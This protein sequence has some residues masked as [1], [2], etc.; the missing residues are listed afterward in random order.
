MVIGELSGKKI[1]TKIYD[2]IKEGLNC[3]DRNYL[4]KLSIVMASD[5]EGSSYWITKKQKIATNLGFDSEIIIVP[6]NHTYED[7]VS[8]IE[9]LNHDK[10]VHGILVQLPL[11][12][13]LEPYKNLILES[14]KQEKDVD[15]LTPMNQGNIN[16]DLDF[17]PSATAQAVYES[18]NLAMHGWDNYEIYNK[19][20]LEGVKCTI[21]NHSVLIGRPLSQMLLNSGATVSLCHEHTPNIQDFTLMSDIVVSATGNVGIW[22]SSFVS[23][24]SIIIDVTSM[25]T[26]DGFRGDF[27]MD[28]AFKNKVQ[29]WT[30][31]PG[32]IGPVTIACLM[33][34]LFDTYKNQIS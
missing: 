16:F 29:S 23:N 8:L 3:V 28:E 30:P 15:G 20:T 17:I 14:I 1:S 24:D 9:D 21:I 25:Y 27:V 13:H 12:S 6:E 5:D 26:K 19:V 2:S 31:V 4:P 11:Y 10:T 33:K 32:G 34:N 22:D 7:V 18:I